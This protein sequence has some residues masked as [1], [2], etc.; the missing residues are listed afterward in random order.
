[1]IRDISKIPSFSYK[2][3]PF[4]HQ[5]EVFELSRERETFALFWEMGCGKS[6]TTLDTA[7]WLF[8][9]GEIDGLLVVANKGSY[10][11][12]YLE[13]VPEHLSCNHYCT[14]Y[15]ASMRKH[16]KQNLEAAME[17]NG[18]QLDVLCINAEALSRGKAVGLCEKFVANHRCMVVV[19]ES[20]TIKNTKS[21][22]H[23]NIVAIGREAK[24]RRILTGTPT[25]ESPL[26][27]YGQCNFLEPGLLGFKSE[28]NFRH[29]YAVIQDVSIDPSK[30][31]MKFERVLQLVN[32]DEL[33]KRLN[34]FSSRL[35]KETCLDLPDK[36]FETRYIE[37]TDEQRQIY[38]DLRQTA[39]VEFEDGMLTST[40]AMA[41]MTKLMQIACGF[42]KDD[43]G[44]I[45][46][47]PNRRLDTFMDDALT[48]GG[49]RIVFCHFTHDVDAVCNALKAEYGDE[50]VMRYDGQN[51]D[52][53]DLEL[54]QWKERDETDWLVSNLAVGSRGLNLQRESHLMFYYSLN[55]RLQLFQQSQDRIHRP[56]Q[57][58]HCT[59]I[60]YAVRNTLDIA[61]IR[62]LREKRDLAEFFM[63]EFREVMIGETI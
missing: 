19:D 60:Q 48:T 61:I 43:E 8:A 37:A 41:T 13:H 1:M 51:I 29:Y 58:Y 34:D 62:A 20:D 15:A 47:I 17:P 56:G 21:K 3:E 5:K 57:K 32:Q 63:T 30:P 16:E 12:W 45:R 23:K 27:L 9:K 38:D 50:S 54:A 7:A 55:H 40:S 35:K 31:W 4:K 42:V 24:Y 10:M 28:F 36:I 53:R 33:S 25:A 14:Y 18:E 46:E 22:R 2:T 49:K 59:Y 6:K 39:V 11:G 52:S 26:D 44:V